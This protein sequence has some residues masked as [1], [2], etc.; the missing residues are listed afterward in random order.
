MTILDITTEISDRPR[1]RV[2]D[3]EEFRD[4]FQVLVEQ[5]DELDALVRH[6]SGELRIPTSENAFHR[7][8]KHLHDTNQLPGGF[9]MRQERQ[10]FERWGTPEERVLTPGPVTL[11]MSWD[12]GLV[13][14][15]A[16]YHPWRFFFQR[17]DSPVLVYT[18]GFIRP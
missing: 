15:W 13:L 16:K 7:L 3:S 18:E 8:L 14:G 5:F 1:Y 6:A 17:P 12:S 9:R 10:I 11:G 4:G 2:F